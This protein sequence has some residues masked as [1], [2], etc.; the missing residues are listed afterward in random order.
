L[1]VV[2]RSSGPFGICWL[3]FGAGMLSKINFFSFLA[4][5]LRTINHFSSLHPY[6]LLV[7][8]IILQHIHMMMFG[9]SEEV[10]W[11]ICDVLG[12]IRSSGMLSK[13]NCLHFFPGC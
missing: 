8:T 7:Y 12:W 13:I 10:I 11:S 6:I 3:G 9:G 5:L 4:R 2:R 1:V